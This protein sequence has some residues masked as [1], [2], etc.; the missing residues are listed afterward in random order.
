MGCDKC[1]KKGIPILCKY[2][3]KSFCT[4]C[5]QLEIHKCD[6]LDDKRK[7]ELSALSK[8]IDYTSPKK[9]QLTY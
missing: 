4:R 5:I 9:L 7:L 1:R 8:A 6:G 2:C 3:S